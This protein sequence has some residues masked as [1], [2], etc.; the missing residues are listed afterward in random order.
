[1]LSMAVRNILRNKRRSLITAFAI[2]IGL[3]SLLF[4]WGFN[5]GIHNTMTRNMQASI[6]GSIQIHHRGYFRSPKLTDDIADLPRVDAALRR[7]GVTDYARQLQG[8]A[9]AVG[10]EVSAGLVMIGVEPRHTLLSLPDKVDRGRFL[11]DAKAMECVLGASTARQL[12]VGIGDAVIFLAEDRFGALAAAKFTLVGIISSGEMGIDR[13]LAVLPLQAMQ[14]W[15]GMEHR[16]SRLLIQLPAERLQPVFESL[17]QQLPATEYEIMRWHDMYPMMYQWVEL[18]NVFYYIF[19]G[20]VLLIVV[21]GVANTILMSMLERIH[22]FGVMLALGCSHRALAMMLVL[23]SALI[24]SVSVLAGT[25]LGL[26]LVALFHQLGIDLSSQ[27]D[28]VQRFYVDPV[29]HTEIN[30][31]HLRDT[32]G[33]VFLACLL[34]SL[35]PAIRTARL[36]PV[37]AIHHL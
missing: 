12:G 16:V 9:L 14:T 3:A 33:L 8:F 31:D 35:L 5:D 4:L 32:V 10:D 36:E 20:I 27:M 28:T 18:E 30:L 6:V 24:G 19:L 26:A 34:A 13:G 21:A 7:A 37:Q 25:L 2:M 1:M 22:E 23:E 15:L 29:V 11:D 17:Q